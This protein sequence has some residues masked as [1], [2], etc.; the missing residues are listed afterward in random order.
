MIP[1]G[2]VADPYGR[3]GK[4]G[5]RIHWIGPIHW[6]GTVDCSFQPNS[7]TIPHMLFAKLVA[8]LSLALFPLVGSLTASA[9]QLGDTPFLP[10]RSVVVPTTRTH[11]EVY[12]FHADGDGELDLVAVKTHTASTGDFHVEVW[13]GDGLGDFQ[14]HF[15]H[16]L[17][18]PP[19]SLRTADVTGDG[20]LDLIFLTGTTWLTSTPAEVHVLVG[21]GTGLYP[22]EHISPVDSTGGDRL[23]V[24]HLDGDGQVDLLVIRTEEASGFPWPYP[25]QFVPMLQT[26]PGQFAAGV[27]FG[28]SG[29]PKDFVDAALLDDFDGDGDSD[30]VALSDELLLVV[31]NGNGSFTSQTSLRVPGQTFQQDLARGDFSQAGVRQFALVRYASV[32]FLDLNAG[33]QLSVAGLSNPPQSTYGLG[34]GTVLTL[35]V[36]FDGVDEVGILTKES[37]RLTVMRSG[38]PGTVVATSGSTQGWTTGDLDGDGSADHVFADRFS[39]TLYVSFGSP[40]SDGLGLPELWNPPGIA[41]DDLT[42]LTMGDF[43]GDGATDLAVVERKNAGQLFTMVAGG[44]TTA[45]DGGKYPVFV[46]PVDM[47]GDGVTDLVM[48]P[49]GGAAP[50]VLLGDGIGGFGVPIA[51][52]DPMSGSVDPL[53]FDAD[54]DGDM[55]LVV[56]LSSKAFVARYRAVGDGSFEPWGAT[57]GLLATQA[58]VFGLDHGDLNGDGN[59]DL[60]IAGGW[61]NAY[62]VLLGDGAGGYQSL[63]A[64]PTPGKEV[65]DVHLEDLNGDGQLDLIAGLDDGLWILVGDGLGGFAKVEEHSFEG[66]V[67]EL[68]YTDV[69]TDGVADLVIAAHPGRLL[70]LEGSSLGFAPAQTFVLGGSSVPRL[71]DFDGDGHNDILAP[72]NSSLVR[73]NGLGSALPGVVSFGSGTPGCLGRLGVAASTAPSVGNGS[74]GLSCTNAPPRTSGVFALSFAPA[75]AGTTVFGML[76]HVTLTPSY[77]LL[78]TS[79]DGG[80][81]GWVDLAIPNEPLLAG[82]KVWGQF[83]WPQ[84]NNEPCFAGTTGLTSS[85]GVELTI[86]P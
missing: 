74:F 34:F 79:S 71:G 78:P 69:N 30:L 27:P 36:E 10:E 45:H 66:Y 54:G 19:T 82:A 55:D 84:G 35:D 86:Q 4:A 49:S 21:D 53:Y 42:G 41:G 6:M 12:M 17:S 40:A 52:L 51:A 47:N 26:G 63:G 13:L 64:I 9:V 43:S 29:M 57:S 39:E 70:V 3:C 60:V 62:E 14:P 50:R 48:T 5:C 33:G 37:G 80:G 83:L 59:Q 38:A 81:T 28:L 56:G 31:E 61:E 58:R 68:L 65:G 11:E 32:H 46:D 23:E 1:I 25:P 76:I 75:T 2:S 24:G 73:Q 22:T 72:H 85:V 16:A 20:V 7:P 15:D 8:P 44:T 77:V 67:N 18:I